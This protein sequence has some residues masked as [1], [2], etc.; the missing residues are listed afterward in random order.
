MFELS[1]HWPII[2]GMSYD[3]FFC[4]FLAQQTHISHGEVK[5]LFVFPFLCLQ[6]NFVGDYPFMNT[7]DSSKV[8]GVIIRSDILESVIPSDPNLPGS[9]QADNV[10]SQRFLDI[11]VDVRL[12]NVTAEFPLVGCLLDTVMYIDCTPFVLLYAH[13]VLIFIDCSIRL[14]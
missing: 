5:E 2:S 3:R 4:L 7:F 1:N 12:V 8:N 9:Q 10:L 11:H 13:V 14:S 6:E